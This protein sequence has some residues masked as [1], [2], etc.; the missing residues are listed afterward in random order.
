MAV[1][2]PLDPRAALAEAVEC[3][4]DRWTLLVVDALLAGP[5]RFND[6]AEDVAGIAPNILS[7]RLRR[8]ASEGILRARPYSRR[9]L[10][11]AYE[12]TGSGRE[13]AGALRLLAHWGAGRSE[14]V[15]PP[16]H[17]E[18]GTPMEARWYCP[19]CA[20]FVDE[21]HDPGAELRYV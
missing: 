20:R 7:A 16:R 14:D 4:G 19:T 6:L 2:D 17:N 5:R 9:P 18:C 21:S 3:V 10:R 12:L 8:L 11:V 1:P 15:E 13:L